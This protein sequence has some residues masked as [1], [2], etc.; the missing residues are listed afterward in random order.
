MCNSVLYDEF[1]PLKKKK[2]LRLNFLISLI[3]TPQVC[4]NAY[5][6]IDLL[7]INKTS[8]II[9]KL[10]LGNTNDGKGQLTL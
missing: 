9:C 3:F 5:I 8:Q 10:R 4:H 2:Q 1:N 7:L 6:A